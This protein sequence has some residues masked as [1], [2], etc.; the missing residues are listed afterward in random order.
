[1]VDESTL[2]TFWAPL[3]LSALVGLPLGAYFSWIAL[4]L[5]EPILAILSAVLLQRAGFE[6]LPGAAMV[7]ACLAVSQI[8]YL[9]GL[10]LR[11]DGPEDRTSR[12]HDQSDQDPG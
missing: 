8:A 9:A 4:M 3:V 2:E 1:M 10:Q 5:A 6:V 7:V 12:P 11:A